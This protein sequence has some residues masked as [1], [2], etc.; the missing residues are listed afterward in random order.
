MPAEMLV[1][2]A[3]LLLSPA[4]AIS[5]GATGYQVQECPLQSC[6][7]CGTMACRECNRL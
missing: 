2:M 6:V 1:T 7:G 4:I 3:T 5:G